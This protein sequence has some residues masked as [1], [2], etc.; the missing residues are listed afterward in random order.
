HT[1]SGPTIDAAGKMCNGSQYNVSVWAKLAPGEADTQL[2]VSIQRSLGGTT[3]FNTLIGNTT[4]TANAWVHLSATVDF[5]FDYDTLSIYVESASGLASFYIDDFDLTFVP[6]V[7]IEPDI[8]SV[9]DTWADLFP[10]GAAIFGGDLSGPNAEL[11]AKH[12][13]SITSEN[14]M[15]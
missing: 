15:K 8:P 6:P 7:Q 12:F 2:R 14:D 10:V 13:S 3:S 4:V 11:L 9:A 1:Y 5:A